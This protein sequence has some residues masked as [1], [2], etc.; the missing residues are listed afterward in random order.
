M[1]KFK[2]IALSVGGTNNRIF[3][4][5]EIVT[6]ADFPMRVNPIVVNL[7]RNKSI[8]SNNDGT[9]QVMAL[10]VGGKDNKIFSAGEIVTENDFPAPPQVDSAEA[11]VEKG[12]LERIKE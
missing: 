11:L 7:L 10:S 2:V 9:Y 1:T 4:S 12:F 5:G 6:D 3:H 8:R